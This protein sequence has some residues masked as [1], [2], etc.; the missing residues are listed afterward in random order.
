[1]YSNP[2]YHTRQQYFEAAYP[3]KMSVYGQQMNQVHFVSTT[4]QNVGPN[5]HTMAVPHS[6]SIA[7]GANLHNYNNAHNGG[8]HHW[9][10]QHRK[11]VKINIPN[12]DQQSNLQNVSYGNS[13][14]KHG[15]GSRRDYHGRNQGH[16]D[17]NGELSH[18][19]YNNNW[20][21]GY[22]SD[23][24]HRDEGE[25]IREQILFNA[26]PGPPIQ[27][28][29]SD[30][31]PDGANLFVFHIPNWCSN[32]QL[33]ELFKPHGKLL[34]CRIFVDK[35]SGRS[36]GFGFVSFADREAANRAID[37]M[38]GYELGHKRLKV[39]LKRS[40]QHEHVRSKN[41]TQEQGGRGHSQINRIRSHAGF[42]SKPAK[43]P[44]NASEESMKCDSSSSSTFTFNRISDLISNT[45]HNQRNITSSGVGS[46]TNLSKELWD[47]AGRGDLSGVSR[48]YEEGAKLDWMNLSRGNTNAL[49]NA[50][51]FNQQ[52]VTKWLISMDADAN[53]TDIE[54]NTPVHFAAMY[55]HTEILQYLHAGGG[56]MDTE[57]NLGET[58]LALAQAYGKDR[59]V[60]LIKSLIGSGTC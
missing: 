38:N 19:D 28:S 5:V 41:K 8:R 15:G 2:Q 46:R 18:Q 54:G 7:Q 31:G 48:L 57:N 49:H 45:D 26:G 20:V 55:G 25:R 43:R 39:E 58:P 16:D 47:A 22:G 10:G 27:T 33:F 12:K 44:E 6:S 52:A 21:Q 9:T 13:S 17:G 60:Q 30:S 37:V 11:D 35:I 36:R 3:G 56:R 51:Q 32:H 53:S 59:I 1:M 50:C 14:N 4:S 23:S 42:L 34:S 40:R 24:R 29:S